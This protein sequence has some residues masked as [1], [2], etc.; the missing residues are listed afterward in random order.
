MA[1]TLQY[2]MQTREREDRELPTELR[3]VAAA[4]ALV[5]MAKDLEFRTVLAARGLGWQQGHLT[6]TTVT[7]VRRDEPGSCSWAAIGAAIGITAQSAHER[8]A[9]KITER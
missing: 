1:K 3:E 4:H 9:T 6:P 7:G 8:W 5:E 2:L